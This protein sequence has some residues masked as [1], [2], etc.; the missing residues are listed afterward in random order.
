MVKDIKS[1]AFKKLM[2]NSNKDQMK[3]NVFMKTQI[4]RIYISYM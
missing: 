2:L 3:I 1:F 4:H